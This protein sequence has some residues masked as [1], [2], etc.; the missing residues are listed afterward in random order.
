MTT[1]V[2]S[3]GSSTRT[4]LTG[5]F[6]KCTISCMAV[7]TITAGRFL[8]RLRDVRL[9]EAAVMAADALVRDRANDPARVIA[10]HA[11]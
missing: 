5:R 9:P 4:A 2:T 6:D 1:Y 3:C 11:D 10:L 7:K 8:E